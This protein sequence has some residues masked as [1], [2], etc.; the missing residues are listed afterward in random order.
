MPRLGGIDT[1]RA[2][3][4]LNPDAKIILSTGYD[5]DRTLQKADQTGITTI[6][7]KPFAIHELSHLIRQEIDR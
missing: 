5:R 1:A 6:I 7:Q 3:R 4:D 2:I